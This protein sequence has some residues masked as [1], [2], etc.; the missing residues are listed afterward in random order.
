MMLVFV[1]NFTE[2]FVFL[3]I[4]ISRNFFN[5]YYL[6]FS[7]WDFLEEEES[8]TYNLISKWARRQQFFVS[9][10]FNLLYNYVNKEVIHPPKIAKKTVIK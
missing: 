10:F 8:Q 1:F 6:F 9:F 5:K 3:N 4:L 2:F 7:S